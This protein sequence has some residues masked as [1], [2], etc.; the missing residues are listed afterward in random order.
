MGDRN[1][2]YLGNAG[3]SSLAAVALVH[4]QAPLLPPEAEGT[5]LKETLATKSIGKKDRDGKGA[6]KKGQESRGG[7]GSKGDPSGEPSS[8]GPGHTAWP[9]CVVLSS[10][11][12]VIAT[13]DLSQVPGRPCCVAC[14]FG[15]GR[16]LRC[17]IAVC[18]VQDAVEAAEVTRK[19]QSDLRATRNSL[20]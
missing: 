9:P 19:T 4:P 15:T 1:Y 11:V 14:V 8:G 10:L 16:K 6:G 20:S 13:G 7:K 3:S 5:P 18:R 12:D 17:S 2:K